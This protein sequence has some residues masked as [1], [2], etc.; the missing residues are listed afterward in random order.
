MIFAAFFIILLAIIICLLPL[1]FTIRLLLG[2]DGFNL[3]I[4]VILA[5]IKKLFKWSLKENGLK[6]FKKDQPTP[7]RAKKKNR[8]RLI[9]EEI[10]NPRSLINIKRMRFLKLEV[11]GRIAT[12]DAALTALSYGAVCSLIAILLPFVDAQRSRFDFMPD[13]EASRSDFSAACIIKVRII[14]II[15][16]IAEGL[17]D[18][19]LKGRWHNLWN[20]ILLRS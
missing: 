4:N 10:F 12:H 9:L 20:R 18:K 2:E 3:E 14:H 13:F 17:T 6:L 19:Y 16:L 7:G 1:S 15:Y 8:L 11:K 5:H